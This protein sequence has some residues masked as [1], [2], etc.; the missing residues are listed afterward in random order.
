MTGHPHDAAAAEVLRLGTAYQ[1]SRALHVAARLGLA[2]LLGDGPRSAEELAAAAGVHAP[3]LRR[4]LRALAAF[5]V[6]AEQA[7]G[8]FGLGPL[9]RCLRADA[10][11]SVRDLVAMWGD[12]D[13]WQTWGALEHSVRTGESAS[14]HLFGVEN[15]FVRYAVD[16]RLGAVFNAGMTALSAT[17]AAA[18]VATHDFR[19][20]RRIV[21][22]A[23]GQGRLLAEVLRAHPE[24]RGVLLD[25]PAVVAG[26][27]SLLAAAGVA[28]RCEVAGGD[29]FAAVPAGGDLY[30][31]KSIVHD[32]D[33][34]RA[35]AILSNCRRAMGSGA[36]LLLVERVL[37]E[38]IE[39][40]PQAQPLVLSDL[41]MLV[42]LSGRE[43]TAEEFGTLLGAA[44]L[45][46]L[47][48][49]PTGTPFSLIEASP[50]SDADGTVA[51]ADRPH[52]AA[53]RQGDP[54]PVFGAG[55]D[56]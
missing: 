32:W 47:H 22:V 37:P 24:A 42:R 2:D 55:P 54:L 30:L 43:R 8:R 56:G 27:P 28:D 25:L 13:H 45:R 4:L 7:D 33:D 31:L 10:P 15:V 36:R 53:T 35:V 3:S 5:A 1:A 26:A 40:V 19:G 21:D 16:G 46:L 23:G 50:A 52:A 49:V 12:A 6:F 41:N 29:M 18:V 17:V 20:A 44:G 11:G 9:G 48:V 39:P 34:E 51:L 14:Q 38:R